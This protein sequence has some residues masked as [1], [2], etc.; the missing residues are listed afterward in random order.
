MIVIK[1]HGFRAESERRFKSQLNAAMSRSEVKSWEILTSSPNGPLPC[2]SVT[3]SVN[4]VNRV[5]KNVKALRFRVR[6]CPA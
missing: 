4:E 3:G 2:I 6:R 5:I 1:L